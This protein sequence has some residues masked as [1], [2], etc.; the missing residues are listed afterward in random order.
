MSPAIMRVGS[1][2]Y[3]QFCHGSWDV[4]GNQHDRLEASRRYVLWGELR[5]HAS[6]HE[7]A[8]TL[9]MPRFDEPFGEEGADT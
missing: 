4:A 5:W 7:E 2:W 8:P 3:A 9:P 1:L 6:G